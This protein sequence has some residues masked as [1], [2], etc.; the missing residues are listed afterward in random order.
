LEI[1][2]N[3]T[4]KLT[5]SANNA[6]TE[7]I[8]LQ[9]SNGELELTGSNNNFNGN[10]NIATTSILTVNSDNNSIFNGAIIGNG[11]L[12]KQGAGTLTLTGNNSGATGMFTQTGGIVNL[13][14][15]SWGGS[16]TQSHGATLNLSGNTEINGNAN[17]SGIVDITNGNLDVGG[18][19]VVE[20]S[21]LQIWKTRKEVGDPPA[22]RSRRLTRH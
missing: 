10:I 2:K 19:L 22:G 3:G 17:F 12:E 21:Y 13:Q 18:N 6:L 8:N 16:Y 1:Y 9:I 14:N 20:S 5:L 15:S 7:N 4:K 11:N